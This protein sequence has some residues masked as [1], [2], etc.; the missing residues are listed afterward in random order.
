[1]GVGNL[2][3]RQYTREHWMFRYGQLVHEKQKKRSGNVVSSP[4]TNKDSTL[5]VNMCFRK[6]MH[7]YARL[8]TDL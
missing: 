1:M 2:N 4:Q 7:H 8:P 6:C 5:Q 3:I